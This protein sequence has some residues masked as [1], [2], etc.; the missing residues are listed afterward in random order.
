MQ[1]EVVEAF[2]HGLGSVDLK[3]STREMDESQQLFLSLKDFDCWSLALG[4]ASGKETHEDAH[5]PE[6]IICVTQWLRKYMAPTHLSYTDINT[7]TGLPV[8]SL[9]WNEL[10]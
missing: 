6:I 8:L 1:D 5:G 10:S 3:W 9:Q 4:A 7:H 2:I